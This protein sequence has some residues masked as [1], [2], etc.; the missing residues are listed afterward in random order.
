[1]AQCW[2]ASQP[3]EQSE[4]GN[5]WGSGRSTIAIALPDLLQQA[6]LKP[7]QQLVH[8]L[9]T[10]AV[11]IAAPFSL[12]LGLLA[13][14]LAIILVSFQGSLCNTD[15]N[16]ISIRRLAFLWVN[17]GGSTTWTIVGTLLLAYVTSTVLALFM[18]L[19]MGITFGR[20]L[21]LKY[22]QSSCF[23]SCYLQR[24]DWNCNSSIVHPSTSVFKE[25][26]SWVDGQY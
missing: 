24:V 10:E 4:T 21:V 19:S 25:F 9:K 5:L 3:E 2:E 14:A 18:F 23:P 15:I 1:M 20:L 12:M 8:D 7:V 22:R 26:L 13:S 17:T 11:V 6:W 16:S